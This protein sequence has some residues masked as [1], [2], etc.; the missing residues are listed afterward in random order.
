MD[1]FLDFIRTFFFGK[2][3]FVVELF[4]C[5]LMFLHY[6]KLRGISRI[7]GWAVF[8]VLYAVYFTVG[9]FLPYIEIPSM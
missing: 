3:G 1:A 9:Y 2:T 6:A 5:E 7:P 8:I 4:I